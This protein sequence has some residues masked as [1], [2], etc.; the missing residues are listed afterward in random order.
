MKLISLKPQFL[1][2]GKIFFGLHTT[3]KDWLGIVFRLLCT[4]IAHFDIPNLLTIKPGI[5]ARGKIIG[6]SSFELLFF[7]FTCELHS[8]GQ[9]CT[10]NMLQLLD[11]SII[12]A[13]RL[14]TFRGYLEIISN[15]VF[16]PVSQVKVLFVFV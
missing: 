12:S 8:W 9:Q 7:Y 13:A 11:S 3:N 14:S 10:T 4:C 1:K 5:K 6:S 2:R 16:I 15:E